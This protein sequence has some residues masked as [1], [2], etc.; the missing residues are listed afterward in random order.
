M[1]F[2]LSFLSSS[3]SCSAQVFVSIDP[4][5]ATVPLPIDITDMPPV[6]IAP[7]YASVAVV[8]GAAKT[9]TKALMEM[10]STMIRRKMVMDKTGLSVG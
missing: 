3:V 7:E 4:L 8:F 10:M 9:S 6:H 5:D 1:V 2:S